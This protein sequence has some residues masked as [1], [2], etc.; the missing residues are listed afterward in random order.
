MVEDSVPIVLLH[1][2]IILIQL[3]CLTYCLIHDKLSYRTREADSTIGELQFRQFARIPAP[4]VLG[5]KVQNYLILIRCD[6]EVRD[7][8]VHWL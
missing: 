5:G 2:C 8:S 3:I 1:V 4:F 6:N 7:V